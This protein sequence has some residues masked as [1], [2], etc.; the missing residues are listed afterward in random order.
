MLGRFNYM[1]D[2]L[3]RFR[4]INDDTVRE[5]IAEPVLDAFWDK[6]PEIK[7]E[8]LFLILSEVYIDDI[9]QQQFQTV[10]KTDRIYGKII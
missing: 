1:P 4:T 8:N 9:F 7:V 10:Y 3:S 6:D 2:V 5:S